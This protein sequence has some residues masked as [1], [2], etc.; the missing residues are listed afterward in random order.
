MPGG[1]IG[2]EIGDGYSILMTGTVNRVADGELHPELFGVS[3]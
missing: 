1:T 3:A 2:I